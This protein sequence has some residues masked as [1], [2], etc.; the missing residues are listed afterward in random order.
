[1]VETGIEE[2]LLDPGQGA[3]PRKTAGNLAGE[4]IADGSQVVRDAAESLDM[5]V[6][7]VYNPA[8]DEQLEKGKL[9]L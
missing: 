4:P 7:N 3:A 9:R 8:D 1:M 6:H 5:C 2:N